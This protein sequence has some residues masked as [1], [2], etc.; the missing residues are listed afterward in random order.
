MFNLMYETT[1]NRAT[2]WF[3]NF[4]QG[5]W[6]MCMSKVAADNNIEF[7]TLAFT[8]KDY[9][10]NSGTGVRSSLIWLAF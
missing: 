1:Q 5:Q 3:D 10:A 7:T 8:V 6:P 4:C 9:S 2:K